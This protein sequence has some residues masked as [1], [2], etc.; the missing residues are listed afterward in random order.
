MSAELKGVAYLNSRWKRVIDIVEISAI[1]PIA[2]LAI[3]IAAMAVKLEDRDNIFYTQER[4]GKG[5]K[6]FKLYKIRTMKATQ[7]EYAFPKLRGDS[8]ITV[9]GKFIRPP[10]IDEL[11]QVIVNMLI[12][13]EMSLFG[14]RALPTQQFQELVNLHLTHPE[15]FSESLVKE[16]KQ[17]YESAP[18]GGLSL[19]IARGRSSLNLSYAGLHKKMEYDIEYVKNA[20]L[21]YDL[22]IAKE[23][24]LSFLSGKGAW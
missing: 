14:I 15:L 5:G 8:R 17:A 19:A 16:W 1:T 7:Q 23:T 12:K 18:P 3:G 21:M 2:L 6:T 13:G 10:A 9:I 11:P 20:S 22:W 24:I 4:V